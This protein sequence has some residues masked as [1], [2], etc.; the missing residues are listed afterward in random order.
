[1]KGAVGAG[2]AKVVDLQGKWLVRAGVKTPAFSGVTTALVALVDKRQCRTERR[3]AF[4][5]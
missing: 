3:F 1:M 2:N 5:T 4:V